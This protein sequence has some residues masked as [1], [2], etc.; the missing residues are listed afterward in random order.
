MKNVFRKI[1]LKA[2][3]K[4][5]TRTLVTITGIL[6]AASMLTAVTTFIAS[7]R[8]Y[9]IQVCVEEKETGTGRPLA[10]QRKYCQ[11]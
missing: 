1:T 4:N 10:S 2:L 3:K 9:M 6:L 5:R 7:L 8:Q 11:S